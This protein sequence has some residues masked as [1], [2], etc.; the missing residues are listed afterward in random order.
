MTFKHCTAFNTVDQ[1]AYYHSC[2]PVSVDIHKVAFLNHIND[3]S[4]SFTILC[5]LKVCGIISFA[6][7][8]NHS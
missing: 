7:T 2:F 1:I 6:E 4:P 3:Q 5:D 8:E